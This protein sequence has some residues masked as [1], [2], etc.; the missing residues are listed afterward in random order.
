[1]NPR[2]SY[3]VEDWGVKTERPGKGPLDKPKGGPLAGAR[4]Q[5]WERIQ[6]LDPTKGTLGEMLDAEEQI[7]AKIQGEHRL[8]HDR[9][10]SHLDRRGSHQNDDARFVDHLRPP[11][12][13]CP[14]E[15]FA[16]SRRPTPHS[17][18][19]RCKRGAA[20]I[21]FATTDYGNTTRIDKALLEEFGV[22]TTF[23]C[24]E[25]GEAGR[26]ERD[27]R[28]RPERL[29]CASISTTRSRSSP[30]R[31]TSPE[32]P[33]IPDVRKH[34]QKTLLTGID[35]ERTMV[36]GTPEAV[37][38][39]ARAAIEESGGHGSSWAPGARFLPR[40]L[41]ATTPR[42]GRPC[43]HAPEP[44]SNPRSIARRSPKADLNYEGSI[45][46]D[47]DLMD[48]GDILPHEQVQIL[49]V[50]NG[51]RFRHVRH[52][53][54]RGSGVVCLNGPAARLAHVGDT[55]I[56]LTYAVMEREELAA[57]RAHRRVRGREE[58]HSTHRGDAGASRDGLAR[59]SDEAFPVHSGFLLHA[60][61]FL[62]GTVAAKPAP[63]TATS[64]KNKPV[65][66]I[67]TVDGAIQP[68]SAQVIT[69][70]IGRAEREKREAL[71]ILLDTPGGLD[72]AMRED[73]EKDP[74]LGSSR[75]RV[76]RARWKPGG[77]RGTF[78]AYAA[79]IAAMAPGTA[80]GAATPVS[81]GGG[82]MDST[83]AHKGAERRRGATSAPS[84]RSAAGTRTGRR[85]PC[86]REGR[87]PRTMR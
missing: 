50:N 1:V 74:R 48:A 82:G 17:S 79:H 40:R 22:P 31:T 57:A 18:A 59:A 9:I 16:R 33:P 81:L 76:R 39:E 44:S 24:F 75:R 45:T 42:R 27:P 35:H 36:A 20:G 69:Q 30:G 77:F 6:P 38:A 21:F 25:E 2:A 5:D 66:D 86:A 28:L 37:Q 65:V 67:V 62:L 32:I 53:G 10:Q 58:S 12:R 47:A 7:A 61:R 49:N 43:S 13:A 15:P 34:T 4:A 8:G 29:S 19:R 63:P 46:I 3:H 80:I 68:I 85:R 84:P 11:R 41:S 51:E 73:R 83:M 56:I 60:P 52:P 14:T 70:A 55:V 54:P 78:I 64:A 72:T 87:F 23:A 71:V 26:P